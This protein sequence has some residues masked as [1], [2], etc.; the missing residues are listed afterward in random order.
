MSVRGLA[1]TVLLAAAALYLGLAAPLRARADA[2]REE[3][4]QLRDQRREAR[5]RLQAFERH[6]A[7][8]RRAAGVLSAALAGSGDPSGTLRRSVVGSLEGARVSGV[9]LSVRP[10][11]PPV[12]ATVSLSAQGSYPEVVRLIGHLVRPGAGLILERVQLNTRPA[13]MLLVDLHG[14]GGLV[15]AR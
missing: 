2:A 10:G 9:R 5:S 13:G 14:L 6:E 11:R 8:R 15:A 4:R 3:F 7:A 1:G 12:G